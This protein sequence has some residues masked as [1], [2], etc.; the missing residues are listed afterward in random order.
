MDLFARGLQGL[1]EGDAETYNRQLVPMLWKLNGFPEQYQPRLRFGEINRKGIE[2]V[3]GI[4]ETLS[5]A[6]APVFPDDNLQAHIYAE[7][8][9]PM[10]QTPVDNG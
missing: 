1:L 7:A 8:G 3:V 6:G 10:P 2:Q 9:L 5:R 4:L